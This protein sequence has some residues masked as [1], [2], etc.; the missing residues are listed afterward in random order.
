MI[1]PAPSSRAI[2]RLIALAG[3]LNGFGI[4]L[5]LTG[6]LQPAIIAQAIGTIVS[7]TVTRHLARKED[8]NASSR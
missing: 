6:R 5:A 4:C 1:R 8:R 7:L 3:V 2:P